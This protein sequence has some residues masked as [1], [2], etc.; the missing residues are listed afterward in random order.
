LLPHKKVAGGQL[1]ADQKRENQILSRD[2]ILIENFFG[3]WKTLFGVCHEL[4]RGGL[5]SLSKIVRATIAMTNWYIRRRP[6]RRPNEELV[7]EPDS[8][9]GGPARELDQ[10]SSSNDE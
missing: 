6:L 2:R 5:K 9:H 1:T 3:R 4:Y 7:E 8:E 10:Q